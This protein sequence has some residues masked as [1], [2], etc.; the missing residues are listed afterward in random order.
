MILPFQIHERFLSEHVSGWE[1][2]VGDAEKEFAEGE[3]VG[4][5][6]RGLKDSFAFAFCIC[7]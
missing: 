6:D 5:G 4:A 3:K 1:L 7:L 2:L